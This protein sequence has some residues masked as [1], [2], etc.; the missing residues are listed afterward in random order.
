MADDPSEPSPEELSPLA[1]GKEIVEENLSPDPNEP[2]VTL[3]MTKTGKL[4]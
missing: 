3:T 2:G 1:F 4:V